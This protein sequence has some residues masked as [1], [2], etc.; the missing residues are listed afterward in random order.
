MAK[1]LVEYYPM[2]QDH[3]SGFTH[4]WVSMFILIKEHFTIFF[5]L[6]FNVGQCIMYMHISGKTLCDHVL[7]CHR[8]TMYQGLYKRVQNIGSPPQRGCGLKRQRIDFETSSDQGNET[9]TED[10]AVDS[11]A[12]TVDVSPVRSST[13][14][15]VRSST[16]SL[17]RSNTA[18]NRR[19]FITHC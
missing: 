4:R 14:Y 2:L 17:V 18:C 5:N 8:C 6:K 13:A 19:L 3:A 7:T 15:L 16:A 10:Y 12:W 11:S 9:S 1:R